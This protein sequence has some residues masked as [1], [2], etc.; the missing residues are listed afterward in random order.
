[1]N[2]NNY[3]NELSHKENYNNL[4]QIIKLYFQATHILELATVRG[5]R[6]NAESK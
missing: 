3:L 6:S 1:M 2:F 4:P 5:V